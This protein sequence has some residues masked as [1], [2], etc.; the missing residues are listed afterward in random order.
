MESSLSYNLHVNKIIIS[1]ESYHL[2]KSC[3][4]NPLTANP[5]EK[6]YANRNWLI[7]SHNFNLIWVLDASLFYIFSAR[8]LKCQRF[9]C[10]SPTL[11]K[12]SIS[13]KHKL[14][15]AWC[16]WYFMQAVKGMLSLIHH[17]W[18]T[19]LQQFTCICNLCTQKLCTQSKNCICQDI[20][21]T[22]NWTF[23]F[24]KLYCTQQ[25]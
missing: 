6:S 9:D 19:Q 4:M 23:V 15:I 22:S 5:T 7:I 17:Q 2:W 3:I 16:T 24:S 8:D 18:H 21:Q 10:N 13:C 1:V 14:Q 12:H 20:H 11:D 25:G